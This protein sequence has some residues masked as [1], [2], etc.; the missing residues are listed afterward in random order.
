MLD[1]PSD[2]VIGLGLEG[3]GVGL[4]I[5]RDELAAFAVIARELPAGLVADLPGGEREKRRLLAGDEERKRLIATRILDRFSCG[6]PPR[7]DPA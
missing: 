6:Y 2:R 7:Y 4:P 3:V 1:L 5:L